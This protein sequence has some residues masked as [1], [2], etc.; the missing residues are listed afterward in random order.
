MEDHDPQDIIH[1]MLLIQCRTYLYQWTST[2]TTCVIHSIETTIIGEPET[3]QQT[4]LETIT[5]PVQVLVSIVDKLDTL[6]EIVC[7]DA[8]PM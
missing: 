1:P 7:K 2:G 3:I 5:M 8:R 6:H 4:P